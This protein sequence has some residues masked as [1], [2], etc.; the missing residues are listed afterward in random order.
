MKTFRY[1]LLAAFALTFAAPAAHAEKA[2]AGKPR[3]IE[4][5]LTDEGLSPADVKLTKGQPVKIAFTRKT[6]R[7]CM[8]DVV[9]P[10][11]G[12]KKPV[13]VGKTVELEFT[14]AKSGTL[15]VLCGMG[16]QFGKLVVN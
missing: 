3:V 14:P 4:M 7:T 15:K 6:D 9:I 2:T 10:E 13:P 5:S 16:M 11:A 12:V 1:A 8:F